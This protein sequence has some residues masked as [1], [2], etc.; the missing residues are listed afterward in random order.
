MDN[1]IIFWRTI[2]KNF[3]RALI[4]ALL[5]IIMAACSSPGV[6]EVWESRFLSE[7]DTFESRVENYT[8]GKAKI[9][10]D[11]IQA[12]ERII[13]YIGEMQE[14]DF[15][16]EYRK[17]SEGKREAIQRSVKDA[18]TT[19]ADTLPKAVGKDLIGDDILLELKNELQKW[20]Y[21]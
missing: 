16:T 10:A 13:A 17:L 15:K 8:E 4:P 2:L 20:K 12:V 18:F 21:E 5:F 1:R 19:I 11:A 9:K 14:P 6:I 3:V 7:V